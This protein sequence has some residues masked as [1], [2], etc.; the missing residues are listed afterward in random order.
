MKS[1]YKPSGTAARRTIDE[2]EYVMLELHPE[3]LKK[4][5]RREFAVLPYDEFVKLQELLEDARDL[6]ELRKAREENA[7]KPGL[8]LETVMKRFGLCDGSAGS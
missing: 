3:F 8:S 5:G 2:E 6:L 7:D 4:D 1:W